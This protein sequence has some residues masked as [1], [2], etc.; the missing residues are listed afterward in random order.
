[1]YLL[2]VVRRLQEL[3]LQRKTPLYIDLPNAHDYVDPELLREV[4]TRSG[5]PTK[6]LTDLRNFPE[7][8]R[9]LV[10]TYDDKL[11]EW[12]DVKQGLRQ[13]CV[14][15]LLLFNVLFAAALHIVM[16]HCSKD[17]AIVRYLT[18]LI[19]AEV[20]GT[21]E[22]EPLACVHGACCTPMTQG[23]SE[24]GSTARSFDDRHRDGLRSSR[25]RGIRN[26]DNDNVSTNAR[27]GTPR[28]NARHRSSSP[29]L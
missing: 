1:M 17:E 24:V 8:V 10:R 6:M 23:W 16:V 26:E 25:P 13:G 4:L 9:A 5:L 3:R 20:T 12:F 7:G 18:R 19:D 27:P 11:S 29:E 21:E 22:Q 2:F 28:P 14:L 15:S